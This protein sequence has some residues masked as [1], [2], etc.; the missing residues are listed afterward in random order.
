MQ[1]FDRQYR[2]TA[3]QAGQ[4]GFEIGGGTTP[5]HVSFSFQRADLKSQN[6]GKVSIWNLSPQHLAEL[7]KD[8]CVV[9]LN[10]GYGSVMPLIFTGVVTFA[11]T[12]PDGSDQRTDLELVDNRIEV[13]DTYVSDSYVGSVNTKTII[14]DAADQMGVAVTFAYNAEFVDLPNGFSFVGPAKDVL[15]KACD[16]SG[17]QW[18]IQNGVLQV[19]KPGDVMSKEVYVLSPDTGLIGSPKQ[20]Q[21]SDSKDTSKAQ[22]GWDVEYLMNAA[23]NIDDYVKLESK[24]ATGFFRVYSLQ[25][26]GDNM[27][28]SWT[29]KA[30]LLEVSG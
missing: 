24:M 30:R 12:S 26:E 22:H 11:K 20:V 21:V 29:C 23:I 2:L 1:N 8:D 9:S 4:A 25:I 5:L 13:R 27:E 18:S 6:T 16:C 17:L 15:T 28:G 3:G 7:G 10:A 14:Q 19:K